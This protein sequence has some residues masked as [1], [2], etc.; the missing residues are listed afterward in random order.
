[1]LGPCGQAHGRLSPGNVHVSTTVA[2]GS[3]RVPTP[4]RVLSVI[5][6]ASA[7]F[8]LAFALVP[9]TP[10]DV[11]RLDLLVSLALAILAAVTLWVLPR[12]RGPWGIDVPIA[13]IGLIA[14]YGA[15]V[16]PDAEGQI[17]IGL[18]LVLICV[19]GAYFQ[20]IWHLAG[21]LVLLVTAYALALTLNRLMPNPVVPVVVISVIVG[22]SMTVSVLAERLRQ[23]ALHDP[24]TGALNRRGLDVMAPAISA[25]AMRSKAAISIG[26]FDLDRFKAYNDLH[27]HAA[28]D[29]LLMS[30]TD[31]WRGQMRSSDLLVRL[32]GD[33]FVIVLPGADAEASLR[34]SE[35]AAAMSVA[36]WS[37]GFAQW[38]PDEDLDDALLRADAAMYASKR[39]TA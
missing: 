35:R 26:V 32:G 3:R 5:A 19:F 12:T 36:E 13:L 37:I 18:G 17:L 14:C 20:P 10:D 21:L 2:T 29:A 7:V 15:F 24:L 34:L 23:A 16:I 6:L 31:A 11:R 25:T 8:A 38:M 33:E 4:Y 28:G 9:S 22:V 39:R 27:G 30:V 1:M